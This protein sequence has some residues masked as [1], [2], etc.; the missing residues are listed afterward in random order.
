MSAAA[1]ARVYRCI[2]G[3]VR[4]TF[5]MLGM[6]CRA[7]VADAAAVPGEAAAGEVEVPQPAGQEQPV[8]DAAAAG[9]VDAA[10]GQPVEGQEVKQEG[11]A[12]GG[13]S[14]APAQGVE[15]GSF[16]LPAD[17]ILKQEIPL[18]RRMASCVIGIKGQSV[19]KLR[20]ESGAKIHVR[21]AAG[22]EEMDQVVEVEGSIEAVSLIACLPQMQASCW[23]CSSLFTAAQQP[24]GACA[25]TV[26]PWCV[27]Q[28][29]ATA[30]WQRSLQHLC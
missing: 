25:R 19:S 4:L 9:A 29:A 15:L 11:E 10:A 22:R 6:I 23:D 12:R 1:L 2:R 14:N 27:L 17:A 20:R 7:A 3:L 8:G 30:P 28:Q 13:R 21:P 24:V 5:G 16:K 26:S 18:P